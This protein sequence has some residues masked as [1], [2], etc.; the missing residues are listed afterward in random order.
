MSDS[1]EQ[2]LATEQ[3]DEVAEA[4]PAKGGYLWRVGC[5]GALVIW[6][7]VMLFPCFVIALVFQKEISIS[8]GDLPDQRM[9]LW[10]VMEPRQEG[11]GFSNVQVMQAEG[12]A[13]VQT[14]VHFWLWEGD[15]EASE[16]C[17]CYL[18]DAED[19]RWLLQSVGEGA[20]SA[21]PMVGE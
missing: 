2:D 6:F 21:L 10:L 14:N 13:C 16:Y 11:L 12:Q 3:P 19:T 9:R 17:E 15:A 7:I 1:Y 20:C 5:A 8:T 4:I 18:R